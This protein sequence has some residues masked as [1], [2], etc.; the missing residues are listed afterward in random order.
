MP[1]RRRLVTKAPK[2]V[3]SS[4]LNLECEIFLQVFYYHDQKRQLDAKSFL[5]KTK[6]ID[7]FFGDLE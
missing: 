3:V 6:E 7:N 2:I 1:S 5:E 4:Y